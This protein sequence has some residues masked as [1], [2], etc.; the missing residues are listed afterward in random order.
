MKGLGKYQLDFAITDH[1]DERTFTANGLELSDH[2]CDS[3]QKE[4]A[5]KKTLFYQSCAG[6]NQYINRILLDANQN[7][8]LIRQIVDRR[9]TAVLLSKL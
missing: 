9:Y 2:R 5:F 1:G 7:I 3:W 6:S 4:T 8:V